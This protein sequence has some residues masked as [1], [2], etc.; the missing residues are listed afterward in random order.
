MF[1]G[2][3]PHKKG[4]KCFLKLAQDAAHL[5]TKATDGN[6]RVSDDGD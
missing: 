1:E 3:H 5:F 4:P 2:Y 6:K